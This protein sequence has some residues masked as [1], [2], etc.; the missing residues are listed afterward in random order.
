MQPSGC[1]PSWKEG[2]KQQLSAERDREGVKSL[3]FT[4]IKIVNETL[5]YHCMLIAAFFARRLTYFL[6]TSLASGL[7]VSGLGLTQPLPET[8]TRTM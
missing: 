6:E 8:G 7:S 3:Q 1:P 2:V 5:Q 4:E